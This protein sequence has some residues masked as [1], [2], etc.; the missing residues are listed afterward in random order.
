MWPPKPRLPTY[1]FPGE[2]AFIEHLLCASPQAILPYALPFPSGPFFVLL[3]TW[4]ALHPDPL[5]AVPWIS[6]DLCRKV[7]SS[8]RPSMT[9]SSPLSMPHC[10]VLMLCKGFPD[11]S[12][13]KESACNA[14][15]PGS[16][17]GLRRSARKGIG[18]PLQYS[19]D[20]PVAQ[21]VKSLPARWET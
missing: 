11:S 15:D 13:G 18:Y 1:R 8:R 6:S 2:Q 5:M 21:R 3:S 16:I 4:N 9:Y 7:T 19:W 12:V 20:S 10:L 17:P 14:G